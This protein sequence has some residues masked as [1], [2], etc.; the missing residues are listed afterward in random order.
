M[1]M[2]WRLTGLLWMLLSIMHALWEETRS[3]SDHVSASPPS[4]LGS[5]T[6]PSACLI[7]AFQKASYRRSP[8]ECNVPAISLEYM[9][10]LVL[11][12]KLLASV[13]MTALVLHPPGRYLVHGAPCQEAKS[14][15]WHA[16]GLCAHVVPLRVQAPVV[17]GL[18]LRLPSGEGLHRGH[19]IIVLRLRL[20]GLQ[21][22]SDTQM[23]TLC[24]HFG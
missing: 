3:T 13:P 17:Q 4:V 23:S 6:I 8:S 5:S 24:C 19:P 1:N 2:C 7:H 12:H 20:E 10:P 9:R 18:T 15:L 22:Q 16:Q 21:R 14:H 11:A